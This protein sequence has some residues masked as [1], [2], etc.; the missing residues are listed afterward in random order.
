MNAFLRYRER[1]KA[2]PQ[3]PKTAS[4]AIIHGK[5]R[6][7]PG[8]P[9]GRFARAADGRGIYAFAC[10]FP[11]VEKG[12]AA[13][14]FSED[15]GRSWEKLAP[16]GPVEAV[17]PSDSGAFACTRAGTLVV[18]FSNR[19]EKANWNWNPALRDSP[20]AR[21]PTW[22]ARSTD[23]GRSWRDVQKLHDDWTGANRDIIQAADGRITFTS[24][25]ML[26]GPGRHAVL[27]Y[28]SDDEG[29]SWRA[30]NLLD[31]G[32]IGHH[33]GVTEATL[34]EL[35]DGRLLKYMRTGWGQFWRAFSHD[36]GLSW[37]AWGPA[38]IDASSA[39]GA[40]LRLSDG[41]VALAWNRFRPEGGKTV[42]PRG[43]DCAWSATPGS[44]FRRELSVS[45]SADECES[46]TPP[47]VVARSSEREVSYPYLFEPEPGILWVTACRWGL[48]LEVRAADLEA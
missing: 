6:E 44:N 23:G 4:G 35:P 36:G 11:A 32:G 17:D 2:S 41:R 16:L 48:A 34:L 10:G 8:L 24:M 29:K 46:W 42:E 45:F 38:G 30:S 1:E 14:L 40:L 25:K 15:R 27:T 28:S 26:H 37:H 33:D 39:P 43:G 13:A 20:G 31:L 3:G 7:M 19:A 9:V 18:A 47:V 12:S 5:A 21:L 22:V